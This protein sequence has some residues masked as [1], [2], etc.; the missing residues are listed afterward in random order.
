MGDPSP[1]PSRADTRRLPFRHL[2]VLLIGFAS[3]MSPRTVVTRRAV[4]PIVLRAATALALGACATLLAGVGLAG[5]ASAV[6]T[7]TPVA[8]PSSSPTPGPPAGATNPNLVTFGVQPATPDSQGVMRPDI[9]PFLYYV[10][11]AGA[12]ITDHVA[13]LNYS[14]RPLRLAVYSTDALNDDKGGFALLPGS[15]KP[16]DAGSWASIGTSRQTVTVPARTKSSTGQESYGFVIVPF[17]VKV[18]ANA[19]PGDHVAGVLASLV[20]GGD[21]GQQANV[22][23]DQ[24]V[25]TRMFIRVAG[26][27]APGI[28]VENVSA[29][30]TGSL[31]PIAKGSATVT[32]TVANRGNVKLGGRL[33]VDVTG[34]LGRTA[35]ISL[36]DLPL[37][38]PG[39]AIDLTVQVLDVVPQIRNTATVTLTPLK[40]QGDSDPD[41]PDVTGS[42]AF[43][44]VPWM[45]VA[46]LL[47]M[48]LLGWY[49]WHRR[50][51]DISDSDTEAGEPRRRQSVPVS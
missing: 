2:V 19:S 6:D 1:I 36:P 47:L 29:H 44:A 43:W 46:L 3:A 41:L 32:F 12:T 34:L 40:L 33:K 21:P 20:T 35:S 25:G 42:A 10:A 31:N 11:G 7:A 8:S 14:N 28:A 27:L 18:P 16:S 37:L 49:L 4:G 17:T 45:L 9:R 39:N 23:L 48:I 38:L 51:R 24:R 5:P 30:Y 22:K 15:T 50:R 13:I 26:K